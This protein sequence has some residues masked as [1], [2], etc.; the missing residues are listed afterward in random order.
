MHAIRLHPLAK[1]DDDSFRR[2][3]HLSIALSVLLLWCWPA[4]CMS[5]QVSPPEITVR[6]R[7]LVSTDVGGTDPDD[8]QSLVHFLVYADRF[9]HNTVQRTWDK[10]PACQP[11]AEF[12]HCLHKIL[13]SW[14]LIPRSLNGIAINQEMDATTFASVI[15]EF[16][17]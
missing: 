12:R 15:G 6:P 7:V 3:F 13:T 11:V 2:V 14:K 4:A 10:L 5:Q 8:F 9:D 16:S 17:L 1:T